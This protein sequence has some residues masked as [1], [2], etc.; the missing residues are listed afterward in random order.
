MARPGREPIGR[1]RLLAGEAQVVDG[2]DV[3]PLN[4]RD[5]SGIELVEAGGAVQ[6][7]GPDEPAGAR[8]EA[9]NVAQ[10][11]NRRDGEAVIRGT[12]RHPHWPRPTP[13]CS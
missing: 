6:Q 7:P 10:V 1:L 3:E 12:D 9:T 5:V 13:P 4:R 11:G 2:P 8:P